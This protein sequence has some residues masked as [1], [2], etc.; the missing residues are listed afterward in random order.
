MYGGTNFRLMDEKIRCIGLDYTHV[1]PKPILWILQPGFSFEP[2]YWTQ[3]DEN[4]NFKNLCLISQAILRCRIN[5]ILSVNVKG[6]AVLNYAIETERKQNTTVGYP[7]RW[8]GNLALTLVC[9]I[10]SAKP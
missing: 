2:Q 1:Y 7:T 9:R 3:D 8:N 4:Y 6:G 5:E 10:Q